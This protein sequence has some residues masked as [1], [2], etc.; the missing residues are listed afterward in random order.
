MQFG[1]QGKQVKRLHLSTF[2]CI[3]PTK[4]ATNQQRKPPKTTPQK[5]TSFP[6][7]NKINHIIKAKVPEKKILVEKPGEQKRQISL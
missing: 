1:I 5:M 2:S 6:T 7:I 3:N 4:K